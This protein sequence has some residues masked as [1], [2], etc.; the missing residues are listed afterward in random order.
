MPESFVY[1]TLLLLTG[2]LTGSRGGAPERITSAVMLGATIA[3]LA[4]NAE[5][6]L[7]YRHVEWRLF[8]IDVAVLGAFIA[9]ALYADRFW[10][11]WVAA[12]QCIAVAAHGAR[13]FEPTILPLVYWWVLGKVSYPM[14]LIVCIGTARH[15]H[16]QQRVSMAVVDQTASTI[17]IAGAGSLAARSWKT[18]TIRRGKP[19]SLEGER[20]YGGR[21][22]D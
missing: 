4:A 8:W 22:P 18:Q 15:Q 13:A 6:A 7:D 16:R 5:G 3:T 20:G 17:A 11:L 1:I 2:F 14:M 10:P 9:V 19:C 21:S 12:L